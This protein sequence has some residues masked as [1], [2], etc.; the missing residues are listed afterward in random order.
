[1]SVPL[2]PR[3]RPLLRTYARKPYLTAARLSPALRKW[4]DR[5]GYITPHFTWKSYACTDGTRVPDHLRGNA[6]R[7]HWKLELMRHRMGDVSMTVDGPYRTLRKNRAVGGAGNSRHTY[8]DAADFFSVQVDRWV[9]QS[10]TLRSRSDVLKI[11]DRTFYNGGVGN[12]T[13]GTL[14]VDARGYKSRFVSWVAGR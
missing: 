4:C 3:S 6:I 1:M 10:S 12:E 7:L 14:H 9:R 13:S 2:P 11:A 5:H 8:A